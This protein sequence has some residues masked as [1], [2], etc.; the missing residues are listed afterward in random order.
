MTRE[1][2][3]EQMSH[4]SPWRTICEV[5]REIYD[6]CAGLPEVQELVLEA[7][8]VGKKMDAKLRAYKADWDEGFY[9]DN[10]DQPDDRVK[11]MA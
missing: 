9:A 4:A 3:L 2:A 8:I 5:H 7:F 10:K 1:E 11:R 6:K